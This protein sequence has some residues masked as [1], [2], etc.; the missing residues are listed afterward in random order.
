MLN[1]SLSVN[2][3]LGQE[4]GSGK[5]GKTSVLELLRLQG[6]K[7]LGII[8]LQAKWVETKI[9][10]NIAVTKKT[11]LGNRDI[12]GLNPSDGGTLLFGG[13]DG[14]SQKNPEDSGNLGKVGD[15][16]SRDLGI[17]EEG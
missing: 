4:T 14:N 15:G 2:K 8:G 3:L 7:L 12:L 17:E 13:T 16:R 10:R 9:T 1:D 11:W 5:H 6:E